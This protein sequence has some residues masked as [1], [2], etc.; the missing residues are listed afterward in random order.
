MIVQ[1]EPLA[2]RMLFVTF[3]FPVEPEQQL[4]VVP[5]Q[6]ATGSVQPHERYRHELQGQGFRGTLQVVD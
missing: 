1:V 6:D 3:A 5:G 4:G 2:Q